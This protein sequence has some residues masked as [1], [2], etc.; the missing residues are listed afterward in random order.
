MPSPFPGMNPYLEA[1]GIWHDFHRMLS[2]FIRIRLAADLCHTDFYA[3]LD[4]HVRVC[5]LPAGIH[6]LE[7]D[8]D[9][10]NA[11][12]PVVPPDLRPPIHSRVS[13]DIDVVRE[14]FVKIVQ[15]RTD[16][17]VSVIEFV[18]PC[19]KQVSIHHAAYQARRRT[20]LSTGSV[21]LIEIDLLRGGER[22]PIDGLPPC[23]YYVMVAR[24]LDRPRVDVWPVSLRERLPAIPVPLSP[25][26][27]DVRLDLQ[28]IFHEVYDAA[29]YNRH[30]YSQPP[31]PPLLSCDA[32]WA[33]GL[34]MDHLTIQE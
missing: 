27:A 18:T 29:C 3:M 31:E 4:F 30:I 11:L 26:H 20:L 9:E 10:R 28:A 33:R 32:D 22:M 25:N 12:R 16:E 15:Q 2:T 19:V 17:V 21:N 7:L 24:S 14:P 34:L 23:D 6:A 13:M 8:W 1:D 5:D